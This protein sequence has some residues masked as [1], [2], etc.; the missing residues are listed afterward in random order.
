MISFEVFPPRDEAQQLVLKS[1]LDK[2]ART[3]PDYI[4]VTFGAGGS[5]LARTRDTVL[6][7]QRNWPVQPVPHISC[8][9]PDK[10]S[11]LDLLKT[12]QGAGINRLVVLRGD[13]PDEKTISGP[14]RYASDLLRF[15]RD[16]YGERFQLEVAC[17]PEFHPESQSPDTELTYLK[18]KI[19]AGANGAITQY[20]FSADAYFRFV[21]DC[22]R[23]GIDV[24][25]TAGIM[26]ITNY[27]QLAR[28]SAMCGAEIP[29]WIRKRLAGYGDDGASI[30]EFGETVISQLCQQLLDGGVPGLH[31]YTLNRANATLKIL[32]NIQQKTG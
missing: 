8:M 2:L 7:I 6:E 13:I 1:T 14:F 4:S 26:P 30:R 21:E 24:P 25:I 15:I 29:A 28:F 16:E 12:Y 20:F 11:I 18:D 5:T 22:Q 17:Y 3:R 10:Q 23:L 9:A 32:R 27:T 31:F 19:A